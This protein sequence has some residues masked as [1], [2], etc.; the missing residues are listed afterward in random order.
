[1]GESSRAGSGN[2]EGLAFLPGTNEL[3]AAVNETDDILYPFR[4]SWQGSGSNDYGQM[5]TGYVDDH[6]PDEF[7]HV[8][9]GANYGWPVLAQEKETVDLTPPRPPSNSNFL[10][11]RSQFESR[12]LSS[13][14]LSDLSLFPFCPSFP[15]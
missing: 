4:N 12:L 6:P 5:I 8:K 7:I 11:P 1:M 9:K 3:W 14:F 13:S 2:A 15:S 10:H